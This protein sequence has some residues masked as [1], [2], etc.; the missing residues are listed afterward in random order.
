MVGKTHTETLEKIYSQEVKTL[1][2]MRKIQVLFREI[3]YRI[4]GVLSSTMS[5]PGSR[6]HLQRSSRII[7]NLWNNSRENF[8]I[9]ALSEKKKK[10]EQGLRGF[11]GLSVELQDAYL[12][13]DVESV[14]AIYNRWLDLQPFVLHSIDD[15]AEAQERSVG[16]HY[17][18]SRQTI[19]RVNK[20]VITITII[21]VVVA[22]FGGYL[23]IN[24]VVQ[25]IGK[26]TSTVQQIE[27]SGDFSKRVNIISRDEVG[28][29]AEAFNSLMESLQ[30]LTEELRK[31]NLKLQDSSVFLSLII[32]NLADGVLVTDTEDNIKM[33]NRVLINMFN[34]K[35]SNLINKKIG[36]IFGPELEEL[37]EQSKKINRREVVS[38]EM[39]LPGQ[40][41]GKALM[42]PLFQKVDIKGEDDNEI[43]SIIGAV[44]L[45]GD[46]TAEKEIDR[47][48]TEFLST[49]SHEL[50]TPLT[51]VYGFA[52]ITKQKLED[53]IFPQVKIED[54]KTEK[55]IRQVGENINIIVSEGERLTELINDVLDLA[56]MEAGKIEL[57]MGPI[58]IPMVIEKAIFATSSLFEQKGLKLIQDIDKELPEVIGNRDRLIQVLINLI[59]NAVKFT[60]KGSVTCRALKTGSEIMI[61]VIDTGVGITRED[62]KKIFEKFRQA[63]DTLVNKPR[64]TGLGLA[65]CKQIVNR[66]EGRIWVESTIDKGSNF[67]FTIPISKEADVGIKRIDADILIRQLKEHMKTVSSSSPN[68]KKTILVVDDE[69]NIRELLRQ[70][71]DTKGY[72]VREAKDG[73]DAVTQVKKERP[74]LIILD[75]K[76]PNLNGFDVT[77]VLKN[78]PNTMD[79][80]IMVLSIVEDKERGYRL[81][82]DRY[83]T[84]PVDTD[85]LLKDVGVLISQGAS[86][87]SVLVV[88]EDESIVTTLIDV[89]QAKGYSVAGICDGRECI[90]KVKTEK[91]DMIIIDALISDRHGI[92][93]TL[94]FDKGFENLYFVLLGKEEAYDSGKS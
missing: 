69:A 30:A 83:Y 84:K 56:K 42:T 41:I 12:N 76:M 13:W 22:L 9:D 74:D 53:D 16:D 7:E 92:V 75:I 39:N 14:K 5:P 47:M 37:T 49:V 15:M 40:R 29:T 25:P 21:L 44:T 73:M 43:P 78:D 70:E 64:G 20:I 89:L 32:D 66:H 23:V 34:L 45:I 58:S 36:D 33:V 67:S 27:D 79:I 61:S 85:E 4:L 48:K 38:M 24:G 31:A 87:K 10:F 28:Q 59:S 62:Q 90:D 54:R 8:H 72:R 71:L 51:S 2:D 6:A 19:S 35:E 94:R 82:V 50:R 80:P 55:T 17:I 26:L 91:P 68:D 63:G 93:K 57:R 11:Y 46:I 65:I 1:D 77:A 81:G 3:E 88:D 86:K 52:K 18:E 60:E